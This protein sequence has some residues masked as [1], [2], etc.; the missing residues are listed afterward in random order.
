VN[1]REAYGTFICSG[2][3]FNH[4]SPY[5]G[6]TFVTRKI[7]RALARIKL[8]IQDH[9]YL[10]NLDARRD[11][12]FA[13]DYVEAMW[14]MLQSDHPDDY[15]IA[16]GESYSVREF[17]NEAA[18]CLDMDPERHIKI[19]PAYFRPSEV[20]FL[21]GDSSKA[22]RELGWSPK[23][24]FHQLVKMMTEHDYAL[25]Q[26]EATLIRAGHADPIRPAGVSVAAYA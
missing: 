3:L 15:V 4:E 2:I 14:R 19:D 9:L 7:T 10:G 24:S 22:R 12:G 25:A 1:Y 16:T 17:L 5:R 20:N 13:G 23:V 11:W 8:G 21:Q 26:Q 6:E 18:L